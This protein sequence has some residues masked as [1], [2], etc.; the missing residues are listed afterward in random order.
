MD[1]DTIILNATQSAQSGI[2]K[3]WIESVQDVIL[4][5]SRV[6]GYVRM[7]SDLDIIVSVKWK[8]DFPHVTKAFITGV[9]KTP[10]RQNISIQSYNIVGRP[11]GGFTMPM[12]SLLNK[13]WIQFIPSQVFGYINTKT[14]IWKKGREIA[15]PFNLLTSEYLK[16][17]EFNLNNKT[18]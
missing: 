14:K 2:W 13:K 10:I 1:F 4:T 18:P 17:L 8:S 11:W 9:I 5:G 7:E 6:Y 15:N 16:Q 12:Y 3:D